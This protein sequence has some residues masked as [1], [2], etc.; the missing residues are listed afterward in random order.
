MVDQSIELILARDKDLV[1]VSR[2]SN[3]ELVECRRLFS[4]YFSI[5]RSSPLSCFFIH[6]IK[7]VSTKFDNDRFVRLAARWRAALSL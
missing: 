7:I 5:F 4:F 6:S 2:H 3:G 1:D